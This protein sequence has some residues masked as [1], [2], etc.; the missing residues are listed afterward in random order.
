M[1][2]HCILAVACVLV[3]FS[4]GA[5][6]A[7]VPE[8]KK[9]ILLVAFGTSVPEAKGA[10]ESLVS[11]A[12]TAHP[13]AEVR[14]AYTSNIIRRKLKREEGVEVPTPS[15]ALAK[16]N[17]D[18]FTHVFVQPTHVI[19]G[20]EY[21]ELKSVVDAFASIRG[22]YGF[23]RVALGQP[24]LSNAADCKL[25][26][27]ILTRHFAEKLNANKAVVLMGHGTPHEA[28]SM[29]GEMQKALT[30]AAAP[31]FIFLG[32]VEAAPTFEDVLAS[33]KKTR[34][35]TLVLAPFMVVAGDHAR[36][37]LAGEDD[38]ESWLSRFKENGYRIELDLVGLGE[39]PEV[40]ALFAE[41]V[42]ELMK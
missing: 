9:G 30:G 19:P 39:Y 13:E 18:R 8:E 14:L 7:E 29:Y 12:K 6:A 16:M 22:K 11:A 37:D 15:E 24:F 35:K 36:N 28:N 20:E 5:Q 32:T 38:P 40:A 1:F 4:C 27:G 34:V 3:F 31:R 41:R 26:A 42:G 10:I 2:K 23:T 21:D 17:D 25:M 33:L